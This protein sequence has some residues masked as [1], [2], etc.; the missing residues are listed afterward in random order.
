M[1]FWNVAGVRLRSDVASCRA[2]PPPGRYIS[3]V[4]ACCGIGAASA[5][6]PATW[7]IE[8]GRYRES[9]VRLSRPYASDSPPKTHF[10]PGAAK[11][12]VHPDVDRTALRGG[13]RRRAQSCSAI[14]LDHVGHRPVY[15]HRECPSFDTTP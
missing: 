9:G 11:P 8:S 10:V 15:L 3:T 7:R 12:A 14:A 1:V 5:S 2:F 13:A 4:A 6:A